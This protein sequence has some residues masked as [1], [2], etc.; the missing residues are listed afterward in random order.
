MASRPASDVEDFACGRERQL[1]DEEVH[2]WKRVLGEDV[3]LV[4][5]R[6]RIKELLPMCSSLSTD[7]P[8]FSELRAE[9]E[10]RCSARVAPL[11]PVV[12]LM[13]ST[14]YACGGAHMGGFLDLCRR[15]LLHLCRFRLKK[16]AVLIS[17]RGSKVGETFP[18]QL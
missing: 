8:S 11:A 1:L 2:L 9:A 3:I 4:D 14:L 15:Y 10:P 12:F 17:P 18:A 13:G 16:N 6:M 5:R 7:H